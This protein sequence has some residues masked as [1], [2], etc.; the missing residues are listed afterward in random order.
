MDDQT[1]ESAN[2]TKT[3]PRFLSLG[4]GNELLQIALAP[5]DSILAG[6]RTFC[7]R[8]LGLRAEVQPFPNSGPVERALGWMGLRNDRVIKWTNEGNAPSY[9]AL[10]APIPGKVVPVDLAQSGPILVKPR[11]FLC[12]VVENDVSTNKLKLTPEGPFPQHHVEMRR[13]SGSG[14]CY[15]QAG[16]AAT[17]KTLGRSESMIVEMGCVAAI[18]ASCKITA[19]ELTGLIREPPYSQG[20]PVK[21]TGPGTVFVQS[22][23]AARM[24][25]HRLVQ[26]PGASGYE[27]MKAAAITIGILILLFAI[28][29]VH[30][31]PS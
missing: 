9:V 1:T 7:Y 8:G 2:D 16:G 30:N 20:F 12:S 13:L 29:D 22:T 28:M 19:E 27:M 18:S 3:T 26:R 14:M 6:E 31:I 5:G 4:D 11:I 10:A 25:R 17:Q 15:I 23:H 24:W 21:V